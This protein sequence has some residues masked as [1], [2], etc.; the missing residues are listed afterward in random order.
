MPTAVCT[1]T[2]ETVHLINE[3]RAIKA[4]AQRSMSCNRTLE[5]LEVVQAYARKALTD[6]KC[7]SRPTRSKKQQER[8]SA[9]APMFQDTL[10][11]VVIFPEVAVGDRL[12]VQFK[13]KRSTALF[14]G[15]FEDL[16]YPAFF[17]TR[18]FT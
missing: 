9:D 3:E 1:A 4:W 17:P 5:T 12:V 13:K 15:H 6:A 10:L 16:S 7:R 14:P 11:K 8:A 2:L 18:Q